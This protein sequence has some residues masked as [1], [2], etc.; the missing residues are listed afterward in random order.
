MLLVNYPYKDLPLHASFIVMT[1]QPAI[2]I[3]N[4]YNYY[5]YCLQLNLVK[6]K[7][8]QQMSYCH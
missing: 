5:Q 7:Q 1:L 8:K 3:N 4:N 2:K 6:N